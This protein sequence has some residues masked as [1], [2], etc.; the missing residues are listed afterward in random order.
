MAGNRNLLANA[1]MRSLLTIEKVAAVTIKPPVRAS[2]FG[3]DGPLDVADAA[4]RRGHRLHPHR[5]G[6]GGKR[7]HESREVVIHGITQ[8][9]DVSHA[10]HGVLEQLQP[11]A[12]DVV[13]ERREPGDV[14]AGVGEAGLTPAALSAFSETV[15]L[16]KIRSGARLANS[17]AKVRARSA[18]PSAQR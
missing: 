5:F 2:C 15:P 18:L 8:Q 11:L 1:T 7:A 13:F 10:R 3:F 17:A 16:E 6:G 9:G 12:A 14:A 4:N